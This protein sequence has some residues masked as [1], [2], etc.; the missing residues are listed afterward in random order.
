VKG[1]CDYGLDCL[2]V[3]TGIHRDDLHVDDALDRDAMTR[4]L[5]EAGVR[6]VAAIPD[7]VW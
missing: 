5:V 6:P 2:F 4:L 3:T 1:A 7:L